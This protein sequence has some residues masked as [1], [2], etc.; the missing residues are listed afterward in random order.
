MTMRNVWVPI[1]VVAISALLCLICL[2][3]LWVGRATGE[4]GIPVP[5]I[6]PAP[7]RV[8][9][10]QIAVDAVEIGEDVAITLTVQA[11]GPQALLFDTP[12]LE[13]NPPTPESLER[14]RFDLLDLATGGRARIALEFHRPG[15]DPPWTLVFNP[16]HTAENTVAPR[17]EVLIKP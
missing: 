1:G 7:T 17:V 6:P 15:G 3:A 9:R 2:S 11:S 13:G 10:I 16:E 12:V 8:A 4:G 5:T 14:A